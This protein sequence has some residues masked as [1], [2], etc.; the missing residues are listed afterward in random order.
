MNI[1][2]GNLAP[3]V[4]EKDL[5]E[6]FQTAG[7]VKSV[8]IIKDLFSGVSKGFGFVEMPGKAE[9]KAAISELNGRDLKGRPIKVNEA[10]PRPTRGTHRH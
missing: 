4:D 9:S 7:Q 6:L 2:V 10:R 3:E 1:F 5:K 8:Q